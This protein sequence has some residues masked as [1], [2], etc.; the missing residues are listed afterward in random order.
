M[1]K[2]FS[3]KPYTLFSVMGIIT[4]SSF[5]LGLLFLV[6]LTYLFL[7][8]G[9]PGIKAFCCG[10]KTGKVTAG[11]ENIENAEN[12]ENEEANDNIGGDNSEYN[13]DHQSNGSVYNEDVNENDNVSTKTNGN[14]LV[15]YVFWKKREK[16]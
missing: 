11:I 16:K 15:F 10:G 7:K 13:S 12:H 14:W 6:A 8:Y 4:T 2:D 3:R 5:G 9:G 1:R